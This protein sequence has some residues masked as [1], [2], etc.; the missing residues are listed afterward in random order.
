MPQNFARIENGYIPF[1]IEG[2]RFV[3]CR[4]TWIV[5]TLWLAYS[6]RCTPDGSRDFEADFKRAVRDHSQS[7]AENMMRLGDFYE[8]KAKVKLTIALIKE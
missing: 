4:A 8:V 1:E 6:A 7:I 3:K 2:Y 5:D